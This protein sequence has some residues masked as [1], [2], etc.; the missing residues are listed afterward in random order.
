MY[1]LIEVFFHALYK[2][3][4]AE[5]TVL[6]AMSLIFVQILMISTLSVEA[7][8]FQRQLSVHMLPLH[9][10]GSSFGLKFGLNLFTLVF[11]RC[12]NLFDKVFT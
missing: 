2:D 5:I 10:F 4:S 8:Y 1:V 7:K 11:V 3:G 12:M 6:I 9:W